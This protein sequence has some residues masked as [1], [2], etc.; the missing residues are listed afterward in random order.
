MAKSWDHEG[1]R[2]QMKRWRRRN[3]LADGK[4]HC[5]GCGHAGAGGGAHGVHQH[6]AD[7]PRIEGK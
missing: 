2:P 6:E 7:S 1:K 5:C 3:P 4:A